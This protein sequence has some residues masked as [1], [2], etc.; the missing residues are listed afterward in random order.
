MDYSQSQVLRQYVAALEKENQAKQAEQTTLYRHIQRLEQELAQMEHYYL[1]NCYLNQDLTSLKQ[2]L[3]NQPLK[4][5]NIQEIEHILE[6][7]TQRI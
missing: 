1:I 2:Q 7:K 4:L 5:K 6:E 3:K